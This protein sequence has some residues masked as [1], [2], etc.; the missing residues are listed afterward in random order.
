MKINYN[1]YDNIFMPNIHHFGGTEFM[2]KNFKE[3]VMP[4]IPK[5]KNYNCILL[6]G[7]ISEEY[8]NYLKSEKEIII[9][10][11]NLIEQFGNENETGN[12]L[13]QKYLNSQDFVK[14]IKYL[15][16][17]SEYA[18]QEILNT[19]MVDESKI[20]VIYNAIDPVLNDFNRFKNV[21][22][23][24]IIHTSSSE[25]GFEI[26][27]KSLKYID[28]D[29]RLNVY[30]DI[31]PDIYHVDPIIK[32]IYKDKRLFFYF[33]TPKKTIMDDLSKSHIFAYPSIYKETFCLSQVEAISS[34]CLPIYRNYGSLEEVSL[35]SGI[36]YEIE[37]S[38]HFS[39][40]HYKIF[41][42]KMTQ[43]IDLVKSNYFNIKNNSE[44][45]N[46]KFSWKNFKQ[47]WINLHEKL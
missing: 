34:G 22:N 26:L 23:V 41:A 43:G 37:E 4:F 44:E 5:I 28:R 40:N 38:L 32:E 9:W 29:F 36:F 46:N 33:K 3:K 8:D 39:E 17:V 20:I 27:A 1:A 19:T 15:I 31:H 18:K 12:K 2:V 30:N 24:K 10:M 21:E 47:S 25:R 16:V 45:I 11:H 7:K 42:E 35:K 6:P 13:V 14:K